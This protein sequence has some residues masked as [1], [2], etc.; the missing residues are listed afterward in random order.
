MADPKE[1]V[2]E[3]ESPPASK[4]WS[5]GTLTY[6]IGGLV[7]LFGWLLWGDFVMQLKEKSVPPALQV[8]L[9]SFHA[10]DFVKAGLLGTLPNA[11]AI[12]LAPIVSYRSD[13]HRGRWGRR[14]PYLLLPTPLA[15]VS[16]VGLAFAPAL[17]RWM[18]ALSNGGSISVAQATIFNL[19]IFWTLFEVSSI[20]C[21]TIFSA[22]INDVVPRQLLGRFFALF[23][24]FSLA[25]SMTFTWFLFGKVQEYYF[26]I[27]LVIGL[28]Y[29]VG[30]GAMCLFVKE[31][32]YPPPLDEVEVPGAKPHGFISAVVTYF[33]DC[34][35]HPYYLW[36]FLSVALAHIAF[37]PILLFFLDMSI[38]LG[39]SQDQLGKQVQTPQLACSFVLAYPIGWLCDKLHSTRVAMIAIGLYAVGTAIAFVYIRDA[40]SFT[41]AQI[42]CGTI[43]GAWST[44]YSPLN[45][46]IFPKSEYATFASAMG[47]VIAVAVMLAS[48]AAGQ[49]LDRLMH[50]YHYIYLWASVFSALS[51]LSMLVVYKKFKEYGGVGGY[52]APQP[53]AVS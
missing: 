49:M 6:S 12:V 1:T 45:M 39:M 20:V 14:I 9:K 34:F 13:R 40:R 41:A 46:V 52:I 51:L 42:V 31:G 15:V 18:S 30:F 26:Q 32:D 50:Q 53:V 25:A 7:V 2:V 47:L 24:I 36:Y 17:G 35:S 10:S 22:L 16:M 4:T 33:R 11:L 19:A 8:L 5:V 37:Q 38:S 48:A 23:R 44:A 43:A 29:G 28:L 27:F 3:Y 21:G